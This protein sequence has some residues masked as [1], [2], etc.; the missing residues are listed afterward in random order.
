MKSKE[1][2]R[3][4]PSLLHE[5]EEELPPKHH[6]ASDGYEQNGPWSVRENY[7]NLY[8]YQKHYKYIKKK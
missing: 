6:L 2:G 4:W 3:K 5:R 1:R 7:Q 8:N